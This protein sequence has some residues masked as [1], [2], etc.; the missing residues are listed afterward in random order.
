MPLKSD[1]QRKFLWATNPKLAQKFE[2]ETPKGKK[3]PKYAKKKKADYGLDNV[4]GS[5]IM[6]GTL[7]SVLGNMNTPQS[8]GPINDP[9]NQ[10]M[11]DP[12]HQA[13]LDKYKKAGYQISD[14]NDGNNIN[15]TRGNGTYDLSNTWK[16]INAGIDLATG[17]ANKVGN[18]N[19]YR[20]E[21]KDTQL[22][23]SP[24]IYDNKDQ[25][26]RNSS[27]IMFQDGGNNPAQGKKSFNPNLAATDKNFINW[28]NTN[29]PEGQNNV[30]YS[31]KG[32]YD[33]YSYFRNGD[34]KN[35]QGGHFPDT[36][37]RPIHQ[38]F[39][40]ES[41]YSTPE[42]PG[43]FWQ[44]ESYQPNGKFIFQDGGK[45]KGRKQADAASAPTQY[46]TW[47]G[48]IDQNGNNIN[49]PSQLQ[50]MQ[51]MVQ[52]LKHN[53][54]DQATQPSN[55]YL[56]Q[57][58]QYVGNDNPDV[59]PIAQ[60][61]GQ[62]GPGP[63]APIF[64]DN[65]NDPR[66]RAYNDSLNLYNFSQQQNNYWGK[67]RDISL[68]DPRT[69]TVVKDFFHNNLLPEHNKDLESSGFS[70]IPDSG[71]YLN[72]KKFYPNP[73]IKPTSYNNYD[74]G[75]NNSK[76][77]P[78]I[79]Y[80][81]KGDK[82]IQG[83]PMYKKPVQPVVYQPQP[84]YP[85]VDPSVY[86]S[87]GAM[88]VTPGIQS[89][90]PIYGMNGT[91]PI[92]GPSN[93]LIGNTDNSGNFYPDYN[94]SASRTA[95]NQQDSDLINNQ[96]A[97]KQY[98]INKGYNGSIQPNFQ[99]G[100]N[101]QNPPSVEAEQGEI[102]QDNQG[103]LN[104]INDSA[105]THEQGGV[106]IDNAQRVLE[107][108]GDKR[109]D[110]KSKMLMV[111]PDDVKSLTGAKTDKAVTHSKAF[112]L[113]KKENEKQLKFTQKFLKKNVD[114][115]EQNPNNIYA[116][117]SFNLNLMKLGSIPTNGE[118]FDKLFDHQE[119]IKMAANIMNPSDTDQAKY[120]KN[121]KKF[122]TGGTN[123]PYSQYKQKALDFAKSQGYNEGDDYS[124][125]LYYFQHMTAAA[126]DP[127]SMDL[128]GK[129]YDQVQKD[130]VSTTTKAESAQE[131]SANGSQGDITPYMSSK[132]PQG[133]ITPTGQS[134]F[135]NKD[136]DYL[137]RWEAIIPGISKLDNKTAQDKIYQYKMSTP[138]GQQDIQNMWTVNGLTNQGRNNHNFDQF[139]TNGV[140]N[141]GELND[142][143]LLGDLKDAYTDGM[144]GKRQLEPDVTTPQKSYG[145]IGPVDPN[146]PAPD[147]TAAATTDNKININNIP[148]PTSP[149]SAPL[150]WYDVAAPISSYLGALNRTNVKYNP[151]DL[152][153]PQAKYINPEPQLNDIQG[154][155][156][157]EVNQLPSNGVGYANTA[158][159]LSK[160]YQLDNQVLGNTNNVNNGIWNQNEQ[161]VV[162]TKNLQ[163]QDD[164]QARSIFETKQ[165]QGISAQK[166]QLFQSL[167]D[168]T[169]VISS[170]D[171]YQREG[172]LLMRL[173]PD[174]TQNGV[175]NGN[176]YHFTSPVLNETAQDKIK[177]LTDL[178][179]PLTNAQKL[180]LIT[181]TTKKTKKS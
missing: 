122:Q 3:L 19:N 37:K 160:K 175:E 32:D 149:F 123:P 12:A 24:H 65:K 126:S 131:S 56:P 103:G 43:G 153:A 71:S 35:Y 60:N 10:Y 144:F 62:I 23:N 20:Q 170:H 25:L 15:F 146:N 63:H 167:K 91:N 141:G 48:I 134:S 176:S 99:M 66:L 117:N 2:D 115:L 136:K 70:R 107:D 45:K 58:Q 33:Y 114:D 9:F 55:I 105:D 83:I 109:K 181:N 51:N 17:I 5:Q 41:I 81:D 96:Q 165:L 14:G 173:F 157:T 8:A 120:G 74:F 169:G 156:N 80:L 90:D 159:L 138:Q 145:F 147:Q 49:N 98:I 152:V 40:N 161:N 113:G 47:D 151:I 162:N 178:G 44:G 102:F 100:G 13:L 179:I 21:Y 116:Q 129:L 16:G 73:N 143:N 4:P 177:E 42:N 86:K 88:T 54:S 155:F 82:S 154:D 164:Q 61:G 124:K 139:T 163:S 22:F 132:T 119:N 84:Q 110:P 94:N 137:N 106:Q 112:E 34:Y 57:Y 85:L 174:F 28:Y 39:S 52:Y 125:M 72:N 108:T 121:M 31:N 89:A 36:Y 130:A 127:K 38:T 18:I 148:Q 11:N 95:Q 87:R 79:K 69:G 135:Y 75:Y 92:Y 6:P 111:H 133:G 77:N 140:F 101:T 68:N 128:Y 172:N 64:V 78:N 104:K 29:T 166:Q 27:P 59:T 30:P 180:A 1:Q 46:N 171:K 50:A 93:S 67:N 53:W 97:L 168:L 26:G 76:L 118:T 150:K 7:Q 158:N 142:K